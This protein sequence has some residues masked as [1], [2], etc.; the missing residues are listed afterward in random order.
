MLKQPRDPTDQRW[1]VNVSPG[2]VLATSEIVE[3]VA[4]VS[5]I[6]TSYEI[7]NDANECDVKDDGGA[8]CETGLRARSNGGGGGH[9]V[10]VIL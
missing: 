8:G 2:W 9:G 4:E 6:G 7:E 1:L 5:V 3:F 10:I